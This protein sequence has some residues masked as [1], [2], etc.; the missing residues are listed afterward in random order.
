MTR[1]LA[2]G[3]RRKIY[4]NPKQVTAAIVTCGGLCPGL[5][6]VVQNLVTTLAGE[7]WLASLLCWHV[8]AAPRVAT[9]SLSVDCIFIAMPPPVSGPNAHGR[10]SQTR[11]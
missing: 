6:D 9:A 7:R 2:A 5:N 10:T 8:W 4:F 11:A 1:L 3:P